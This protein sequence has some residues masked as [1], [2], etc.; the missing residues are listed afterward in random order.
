MKWEELNNYLDIKMSEKD[1]MGQCSQLYYKRYHDD[2]GRLWIVYDWG[3][4][5]GGL[6]YIFTL[7]TI[8][9]KNFRIKYLP[10]IDMYRNS[11]GESIR[12]YNNKPKELVEHIFDRL[13][14]WLEELMLELTDWNKYLLMHLTNVNGDDTV[15]ASEKNIRRR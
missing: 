2:V 11:W 5:L 13:S 9:E 4:G 10:T 8:D 3:S 15:W 6:N 1:G 14:E 7:A 12:D